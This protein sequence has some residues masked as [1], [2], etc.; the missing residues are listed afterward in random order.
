MTLQADGTKL[1][2]M[3][4]TEEGEAAA[5]QLR[6]QQAAS[7]QVGAERRRDGAREVPVSGVLHL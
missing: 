7:F 3:S 6:I 1:Q 2:R 5:L 4:I